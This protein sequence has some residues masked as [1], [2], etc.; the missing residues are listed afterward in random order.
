[1]N[2]GGTERGSGSFV[3]SLLS[4]CRSASLS[5]RSLPPFHRSFTRFLACFSLS[6]VRLVPRYGG[7]T[8]VERVRNG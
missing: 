7:G 3:T 1:M 4:S 2:G 6:V 8:D 5:L